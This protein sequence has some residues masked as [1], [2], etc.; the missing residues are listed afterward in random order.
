ML[1]HTIVIYIIGLLLTVIGVFLLRLLKQIDRLIEIVGELKSALIEHQG[2]VSVIEEKIGFHAKALE[3]MN[4]L[5][6]LVRSLQTDMTVLK[7]KE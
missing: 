2:T 4:K 5:W 3:D 1:E 6:E 7:S